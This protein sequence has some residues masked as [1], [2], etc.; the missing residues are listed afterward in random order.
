YDIDKR[1]EEAQ[2]G[3]TR[4]FPLPF[5]YRQQPCPEDLFGE[6]GQHQRE[7]QPENGKGRQAYAEIG[8]AEID[9]QDEDQRR[10]RA[11]HVR[12]YD[13][14]RT[15]RQQTERADDRE[16]ESER[17]AGEHHGGGDLDRYRNAFHDG[18][19][20]ALD[21]LPVE[22]HVDEAWRALHRLTGP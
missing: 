8:E 14:E 2:A 17:K 22:K 6:R 20:V 9:E 21:Q 12:E 19:E 3:G 7:N 13:N 1:F 5:R 15:N 16:D 4:R 18:G 11:K 10:Q